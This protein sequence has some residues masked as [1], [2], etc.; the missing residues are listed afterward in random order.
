MHSIRCSLLFVTDVAWSLLVY[1]LYTSV[2]LAKMA[3][4]TEMSLGVWTHG[5]K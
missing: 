1:V 3:Q 4:P 5:P 2:S